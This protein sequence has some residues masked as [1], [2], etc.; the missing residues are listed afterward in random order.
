MAEQ[1]LQQVLWDC[2]G[3]WELGDTDFASNFSKGRYDVK[4][5]RVAVRGR[6]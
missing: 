6:V 4:I 5:V 1:M 3:E 2:D